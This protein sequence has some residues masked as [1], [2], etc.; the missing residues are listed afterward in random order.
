MERFIAICLALIVLELGAML[1][2]FAFAMFKVQHAAQA[3]EIAAYRVDNEVHHFGQALRSG[4]FSAA[5]TLV[6]AGVGFLRRR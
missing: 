3:V 1:A 4:W 2:I 5:R 6:S